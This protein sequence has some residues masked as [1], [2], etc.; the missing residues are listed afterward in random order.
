MKQL[1]L[2]SCIILTM[3][4]ICCNRQSKEDRL[5]IRLSQSQ[6]FI[7]FNQTLIKMREQLK[8][9]EMDTTLKSKYNYLGSSPKRDSILKY[10]YKSDDF[11]NYSSKIKETNEKINQE[12]PE[13]EKLPKEI[14]KKVWTKASAIILA[15]EQINL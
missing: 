11:K 9:V 10:F 12:F 5:A 4:M 14:K 3:L 15:N 7:E 2:F 1:I 6:S 8:N 13:L